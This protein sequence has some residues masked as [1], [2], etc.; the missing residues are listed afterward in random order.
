MKKV[1]F[2]LLFFVGFGAANVNSQVRIGGD[3]APND[4][5]VLDLNADD[6]TNDGTKG[7]ALPRVSLNDD[8]TPLTGTPVIDGIMVYNTNTSMAGGSGVGIYYWVNSKWVKMLNSDLDF[9]L[10]IGQV[11]TSA[12][13]SGYFFMSDGKSFVPIRFYDRQNLITGPST[14]LSPA[15]AT[16]WV[17]TA[18]FTQTITFE[19]NAYT[20]IPV[21]GV[22]I[23]DLCYIS[24]DYLTVVKAGSAFVT[25]VA[26][27]NIDRNVSV[28]L[29]CYRPSV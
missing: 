3:G 1:L 16:T 11:T 7:L 21:P 5:A 24:S 26:L 29:R 28:R 13:D 27:Q 15:P 12:S 2:L 8:G 18:D 10:P 9:T 19:R 14:S 17:K 4:A 23:H 22:T 25:M 20:R 6:D